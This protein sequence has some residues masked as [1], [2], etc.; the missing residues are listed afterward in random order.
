MGLLSLTRGSE[1]VW[2][3]DAGSPANSTTSSKLPYKTSSKKERLRDSRAR[4]TTKAKK[5]FE[6]ATS[7]T[8]SDKSHDADGAL[9][10][11]QDDPA[12]NPTR[13]KK[14]LKVAQA[15]DGGFIEQAKAAAEVSAWSLAHPKQAAKDKVMRLAA[16]KLS[17]IQKP[18]ALPKT[19]LELLHAHDAFST[20]GSPGSS[21]GPSPDRERINRDWHRNH[22]RV[23]R[24]EQH[25]DSMWVAWTT[26]H[27]HRVRVVPKEHVT[28]PDND[29]FVQRD[30]EGNFVR[31]KWEK[32]LGYVSTRNHCCSVMY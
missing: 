24:L 3:T 29:C 13:V 10:G 30:S 7:G 32:W 22:T 8:R 11:I 9:Q 17:S 25:R 12:F 23:E 15:K 28:I 31:Y 16:G 26:R 18:H 6:L 14:E 20:S 27:T 5:A 4:T 2:D 1:V 19:G 21:R